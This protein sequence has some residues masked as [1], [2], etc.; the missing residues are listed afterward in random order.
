[1]LMSQAHALQAIWAYFAEIGRSQTQLSKIQTIMSIALKAQSQCRMTLETLAVIKN[2]PN[3]AFVRQ[4]NV[5][6]NQQVNNR[7]P[8]GVA[9]AEELPIQSNELLEA[10]RDRLDTRATEEAI[11]PDSYLEALGP[12]NRSKDPRG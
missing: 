1:M 8:A 4:Q 6:V 2:P 3:V 11:R 10:Q 7:P 5:A 12:V 9:R